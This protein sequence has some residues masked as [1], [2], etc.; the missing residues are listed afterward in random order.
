[1]HSKISASLPAC[2]S[3]CLSFCPSVHQCD[4][5]GRLSRCLLCHFFSPLCVILLV[6]SCHMC[7]KQSFSSSGLC[8]LSPPAPGFVA[9]IVRAGACAD[10]CLCHAGFVYA[11]MCMCVCVFCNAGATGSVFV[12]GCRVSTC[13]SNA[14]QQGIS[15]LLRQGHGDS[16]TQE[17]VEPTL[18][19]QS[20]TALLQISPLLQAGIYFFFQ[21][22][23]LI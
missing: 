4:C 1:M 6:D 21:F 18:S 2:L 19:L 9:W 5:P 10:M 12:C 11:C 14:S 23:L 8:C 22:Y 15:Y 17:Q 3:V 13:H 7:L 16:D 20:S